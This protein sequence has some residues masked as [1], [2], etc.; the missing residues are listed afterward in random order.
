[1]AEGARQLPCRMIAAGKPTIT[2]RRE[3]GASF[4]SSPHSLVSALRL[5]Q[6]PRCRQD[7]LDGLAKLPHTSLSAL[8]IKFICGSTAFEAL[9]KPH[10]ELC[11]FYIGPNLKYTTCWNWKQR[12]IWCKNAEVMYIS[13]AYDRRAVSWICCPK[14]GIPP[15]SDSLNSRLVDSRCWG[16]NNAC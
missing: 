5:G 1:M 10:S 11:P 13:Q 7:L 14:T 3:L 16:W 8:T 6:Y 4:Q 9:T 15:E 2:L 12:S